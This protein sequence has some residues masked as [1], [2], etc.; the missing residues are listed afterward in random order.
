MP[1]TS[2]QSEQV[3]RGVR[4]TVES[5]YVPGRSTPERAYYFF[6]YRVFIE[7]EGDTTVQLL[8]RHWVIT[9][10]DGEAKEVRGPGVIG[11]Q[12]V[13][14][15][16]ESFEYTSFCPLPTPVGAMNGSY[17]MVDQDTNEAFDAIIAPFTLA[18]PGS[19]H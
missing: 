1:V 5:F 7:N 11:Q 19:L 14:E 18:V 13:L 10:A 8:T 16:G 6:A 4:V 3:T 17:Q 12:P 2:F 15:P 9:N